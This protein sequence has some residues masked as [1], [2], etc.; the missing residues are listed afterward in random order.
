MP[1][2]SHARGIRVKLQR[3][4]P[5]LS[6]PEQEAFGPSMHTDMHMADDNMR[7]ADRRNMRTAD[8][9]SRT[10]R[11]VD[12]AHGRGLTRPD[13]RLFHHKHRAVMPKR[14][15]ESRLPERRLRHNPQQW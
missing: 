12:V 14:A 4:G 6:G 5:R 15:L 10:G 8:R 11:D 13:R 9:R 7:T 1:R 2:A 3:N